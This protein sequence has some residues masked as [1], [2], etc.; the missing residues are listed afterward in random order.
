MKVSAENYFEISEE[1]GPVTFEGKGFPSAWPHSYIDLV[2][3]DNDLNMNIDVDVVS[4]SPTSMVIRF[5]SGRND[6]KFFL[7]IWVPSGK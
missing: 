4:T 5:P 6:Q 2:L 1:G 7:D 3:Q